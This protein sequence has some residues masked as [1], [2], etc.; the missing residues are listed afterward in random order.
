MAR[1]RLLKAARAGAD[2]A[3]GGRGKVEI[4]RWCRDVVARV[5]ALEPEMQS[6]TD[7]ALRALTGS[8]RARL[9]RGEPLDRLLPE[10][11]AAV[12]QAAARPVGQRHFDVQVMGGAVLPLGKIPE[13]RSGDG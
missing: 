1:V 4:L 7:E 11:F 10:A 8:F 3:P 5:N 9:D 12:R 2:S 13:M 6:R